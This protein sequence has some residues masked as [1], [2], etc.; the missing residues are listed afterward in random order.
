MSFC[1]KCG[2]KLKEGD[3]FCTNCGAKVES[4]TNP[5]DDE[6]VETPPPTVENSSVKN[7]NKF[8]KLA[9]IICIIII[10]IFGL[11]FI[12]KDSL[13][14]QYYTYKADK[15]LSSVAKLSYSDKALSYKN[16][17]TAVNNYENAVRQN[18]NNLDLITSSLKNNKNRLPVD[19]YNGLFIDAYKL[20][21]KKYV[22]SKDNDNTFKTFIDLGKYGYNYRNDETYK[23][24]MINLS[25]SV[26]NN[27]FKSIKD[28]NDNYITYGDIN[29]DGTDEIVTVT[30]LLY[31]DF[32]PNA[33]NTNID[34]NSYVIAYKFNGENFTKVDT[35]K[36]DM[37]NKGSKVF[38]GK[39]N[40]DITALILDGYIGVHYGESNAYF[41]KDN[42]LKQLIPKYVPVI[43][44]IDPKDID[45]DGFIEF[46][47]EDVDPNSVDQSMAGSDKI[48]TWLKVDVNGNTKEVKKDYIKNKNSNNSSTPQSTT[49][50]ITFAQAENIIN[51]DKSVN[52]LL[53]H[54]GYPKDIFRYSQDGTLANYSKNYYTFAVLDSSG[55]HEADYALC[56]NKNTGAVTVVIPTDNGMEMLSVDALIAKT[57]ST[58]H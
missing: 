21:L 20:Q 27:S 28:L 48:V 25:N 34:S 37:I 2:S 3:L 38:I 1:I 41:L 55:M 58:Q 53:T 11:G 44:P 15:S 45:N 30:H 39:P 33:N 4:E 13:Y 40:K 7:K 6:N 32:N 17:T 14:F 57:Q 42:K 43:Y 23:N 8:P 54:V 36:I 16:N 46:P 56:V 22:D 24:T 12:L 50:T 51:T 26:T 18:I 9:G 29:N 35:L 10:L 52:K 31:Y 49:S 47:N 5:E 19:I